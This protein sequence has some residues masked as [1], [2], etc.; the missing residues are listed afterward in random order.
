MKKEEKH[1]KI[2]FFS[3]R[4]RDSPLHIKI[5]YKLLNF[6]IIFFASVC[7]RNNISK[8]RDLMVSLISFL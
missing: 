5:L 6:A 4:D 3:Y 2:V 8:E 7:V 1:F